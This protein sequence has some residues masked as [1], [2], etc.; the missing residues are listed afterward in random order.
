LE[1]YR[2]SVLAQNLN[3]SYKGPTELSE[4]EFNCA[5]NQ[6]TFKFSLFAK[7]RKFT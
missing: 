7:K 6:S 5:G 1:K 3:S 2:E 4:K